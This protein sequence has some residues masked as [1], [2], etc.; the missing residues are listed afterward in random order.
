MP[1][2]KLSR[3]AFHFLGE[4]HATTLPS[5]NI[6]ASSLKTP[7]RYC[8]Y[9]SALTTCTENRKRRFFAQFE[10]VADLSESGLFALSGRFRHHYYYCSLDYT[11][12]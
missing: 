4:P 12:L 8:T 2:G 10:V 3:Y 5:R 9:A 11:E 1:H 6:K 7:V